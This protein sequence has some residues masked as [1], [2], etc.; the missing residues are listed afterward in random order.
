MSDITIDLRI[1]ENVVIDVTG[2]SF[3]DDNTRKRE[4][5]DSR[6]L[7]GSIATMVT[8]LAPEIIGQYMKRDRSCIYYY[9]SETESLCQTNKAF[10]KHY[11]ACLEQ[12]KLISKGNIAL[13][14]R[15][16]YHKRMVRQLEDLS[17]QTF[18]IQRQF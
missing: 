8:R 11:D 4:V 5:V 14:T 2:Y 10:K 15:L 9:C 12:L 6:K 16:A 13:W 7:F 18:A 1:I 17:K 3:R